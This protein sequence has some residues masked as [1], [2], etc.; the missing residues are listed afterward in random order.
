MFLVWFVCWLVHLTVHDQD[1]PKSY[2]Q[3]FVKFLEW[4]GLG[5]RNNG[6]DFMI[7]WCSVCQRHLHRAVLSLRV[8]LDFMYQQLHY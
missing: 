7:T 6:L 5:T 3:I 1:S 4:L 8:L 2:E